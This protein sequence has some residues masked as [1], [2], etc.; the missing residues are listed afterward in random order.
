[1]N[2]VEL[3]FPEGD[4]GIRIIS[5]DG[6][7]IEIVRKKGGTAIIEIKKYDD[8][9]D[10]TCMGINLNRKEVRAVVELLETRLHA[11]KRPEKLYNKETAR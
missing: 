6:M 9:G 7:E 4:K 3:K 8:E 10:G 2:L 1:M 11:M 5:N